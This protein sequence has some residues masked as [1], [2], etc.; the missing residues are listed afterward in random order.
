MDETVSKVLDFHEA[1]GQHIGD[2]PKVMPL[3]GWPARELAVTVTRL[4]QISKRLKTMAGRH[5]SVALLRIH[6]CT[7][8]LAELAAAIAD[9][10]LTECLDALCDMRYVADGTVVS[11]GMQ[12]VFADA[13]AEVH[14]SNMA[15]L[16]ADGK[17]V[18]D[19]SGRV[20][21]PVGWQPPRLS[22]F[23]SSD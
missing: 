7:E 16:D 9:G 14:R 4:Q 8:E 6:L 22:Q 5:N 2:E 1:F 13:F 23:V 19:E 20:S 3:E 10:D 11:L 17:P 15:K 18:I 21:K 12:D